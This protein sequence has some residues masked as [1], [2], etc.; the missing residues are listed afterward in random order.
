V[1]VKRNNPTFVDVG[2]ANDDK[3][4]DAD[5]DGIDLKSTALG[6]RKVSEDA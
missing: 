3:G 4:D 1:S 6:K 5:T 2:R